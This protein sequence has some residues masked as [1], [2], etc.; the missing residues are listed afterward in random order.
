[1]NEKTVEESDQQE[2]SEKIISD[3]IFALNL[4]MYTESFD[5]RFVCHLGRVCI[6]V[7]S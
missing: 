4:I 2:E 1:M 7:G 5:S 6:T 3:K